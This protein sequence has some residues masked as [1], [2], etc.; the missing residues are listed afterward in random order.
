MLEIRLDIVE[1]MLVLND[2]SS[3]GLSPDWRTGISTPQRRKEVGEGWAGALI[4][5]VWTSLFIIRVFAKVS[6]NLVNKIPEL[7]QR[8]KISPKLVIQSRFLL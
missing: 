8:C 2:V 3:L 5:F 6:N 4:I 7:G 1:A